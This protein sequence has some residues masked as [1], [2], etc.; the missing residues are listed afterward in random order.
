MRPCR[1]PKGSGF[2]KTKATVSDSAL[3]GVPMQMDTARNRRFSGTQMRQG[4]KGELLH[5]GLPLTLRSGWVT[6]AESRSAT[7]TK[8]NRGAHERLV[9]EAVTESSNTDWV[10]KKASRESYYLLTGSSNG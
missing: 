6:G 4:P 10:R 5:Q 8:E 2:V 9:F 3:T 1:E 7:E